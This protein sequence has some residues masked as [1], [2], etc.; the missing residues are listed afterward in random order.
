MA[1]ST[2]P[3]VQ[4]LPAAHTSAVESAGG[5]ASLA[6]A[7]LASPASQGSAPAQG[8]LPETTDLERV[9]SAVYRIIRDRLMIERESRGL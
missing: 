7:S 3:G 4:R 9:A 2:I 1:D 5:S 6:G 8:V